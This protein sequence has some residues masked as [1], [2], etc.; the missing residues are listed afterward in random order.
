MKF[1]LCNEVISDRPIEEQFEFAA[2]LSYDGL[3]IAPF[4]LAE[5]PRLITKHT[6]ALVKKA[7]S[8]AGIT[9][10]GLHWLLVKPENLSITSS[11]DAV[12]RETLEVLFANVDLC[13][14]LGGKV[15][16]HGSP[17]QR[18]IDEK[19]DRAE[20]EKRTLE[21]FF[22]VAARAEAAGVLYC[23]E[24]LRREMTNYINTISDA[25]SIVA[26]I[27]SSAFKTMVDT[28]AAASTESVP[29]EQLIRHW[30]PTGHL[31]HVQFN[32]QNRRAAGQGDDRFLEIL[33]ALKETGYNG[34]IAMEPFLYEPNR[35]ACAAF[36][37]G[38]IRGLFEGLE[39]QV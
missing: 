23:L 4:T 21:I 25:V 12:R 18:M 22:A 34:T 37:M 19:E 11:E 38:Y 27:N 24:P 1:S 3:E 33:R 30:M 15:L 35:N 16:V 39:A 7:A 6:V 17:R 10:T 20:A 32:D 13:A 31:A 2:S 36:T 14:E 9:V 8:D 29:V 5:D 26:Q 28:S